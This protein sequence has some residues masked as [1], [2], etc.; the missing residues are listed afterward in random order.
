MKNPYLRMMA[1]VVL[2]VTLGTYLYFNK[3]IYDEN[4]FDGIFAIENPRK[5][6]T[7]EQKNIYV[8]DN[9][10][11]RI[12]KLNPQKKVEFVI[13]GGIKNSKGFY[14]A[15]D[16]VT[17]SKGNI[18]VLDSMPDPQPNFSGSERIFKFDGSGRLVK[19]IYSKEYSV[20]ENLHEG[21]AISL[22]CFNDK[23]YLAQRGDAEISIISI[24][25]EMGQIKQEKSISFDNP[26]RNVVGLDFTENLKSIAFVTKKGE[27]WLWAGDL[28]LIA[29][30]KER[31]ELF[32]PWK[33]RVNDQG[34]VF[35]SDVESQKIEK[36]DLMTNRV[37]TIFT[38]EGQIIRSFDNKKGVIAAIGDGSIVA[39]DNGNEVII[40][41]DSLALSNTML[42]SIVAFWL[43][44]VLM[45]ILVIYLA[46]LFYVHILHKRIST[47]F[48]QSIVIIVFVTATAA[49]VVNVM[50]N[51]FTEQYMKDLKNQ[52]KLVGQLSQ[53]DGGAQKNK[54]AFR[55]HGREL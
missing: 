36:F 16:L 28:K 54:Y 8:I 30:D 29:S 5:I 7:D 14:G 41:N 42:I 6:S 45:L 23:I 24:D 26:Q 1:V 9:S 39:Y 19:L 34:E 21:R 49:I 51:S 47:V 55:L 27:I 20:E 3:N 2:L 32:I 50:Y 10:R 18:Y 35:F 31:P 17:D 38:M 12:V 15:S 48:L 43:C 13:N 52:F 53:K 22:R 4:Y 46:R 40:E 44:I 11:R 25:Q 37:S 33:V